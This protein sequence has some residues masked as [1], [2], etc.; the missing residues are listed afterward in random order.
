MR[1]LAEVS[2]EVLR[3]PARL[4]ATRLVCV[5]GRSGAGKT[6]FAER[7]A[8]ALAEVG[9]G[10]SA[11]P[12]V[13]TDDLLDGWDDQFTFWP[14]LVDAVLDPLRDGRP[15]R[16][17][18]YDWHEGRFG[19]RVVEVPPAP[20]VIME[21]VSCGRAQARPSA[22]LLV[23]VTATAE[24]R[25]ARSLARD[26]EAMRAHLE[27]WRRGEDRHFAADA[28]AAYADLIVDTTDRAYR[29]LPNGTP[30]GP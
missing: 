16:F 10:E 18:A 7:L 23:L 20:V 4:G 1:T 29:F 25:L 15:A 2:A 13:H 11:V 9:G 27:R 22:S 14:R 12:V 21:G 6:L 24:V 17:P 5:D 8:A 19:D 26:G 28:T 3:R 30:A